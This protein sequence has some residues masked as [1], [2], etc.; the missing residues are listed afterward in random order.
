M[1]CVDDRAKGLG[2]EVG[3][4]TLEHR[5]RLMNVETTVDNNFEL[6]EAQRVEEIK[7]TAIPPRDHKEPTNS[8]ETQNATAIVYQKANILTFESVTVH[9]EVRAL[10]EQE[11]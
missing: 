3:V 2:D 9:N 6:F 8:Q 7:V 1:V 10:L 5:H 11:I 4:E